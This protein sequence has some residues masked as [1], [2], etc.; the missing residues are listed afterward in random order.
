[1]KIAVTDS[2]VF[3]D[4]F[5]LDEISAFFQLPFEIHTT[6]LIIEELF[7]EQKDCL[8]QKAS[9]GKLTIYSLSLEDWEH[10]PD[11]GFSKRLTDPDKSVLLYA[12]AIH[13]LVLSGDKLIRTKAKE[14]GL[15]YHGILWIMDKL[16]E[17]RLAQ[18]GPS[19]AKLESLMKRNPIY[20]SSKEMKLGFDKLLTKWEAL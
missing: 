15:E 14:L 17:E 11:F 20:K 9:L 16:V 6:S 2:S 19:K 13:A 3:I 7:P 8:K 1:M 5:L 4:L 18:P 10:A 12:S